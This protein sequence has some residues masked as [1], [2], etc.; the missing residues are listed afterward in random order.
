MTKCAGYKPKLPRQTTAEERIE[1]QLLWLFVYYSF[2]GFLLEVAFARV[3]R[4]PKKDRKCF[5]L[6]PLC[7]VYGIG[8]L[9]IRGL[10]L[11]GRDP[12]WV[13]AVGFVAATVAELLTGAFYR[14]GLGV[15]FWNYRDV[16][17]NF[18]GLVCL[19]FSLCW[20]V[21]ALGMVYWLGPRAAAFAAA[22]PRWMDVP[23]LCLLAADGAVSAVA[24]R[25]TGTTDVLRW[26][27]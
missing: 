10:T 6:L 13:A 18:K 12:L 8:A 9:M 22:V 25:R 7:P 1:L 21:L 2:L 27:E 24:L 19:P 16:K 17:W 4:H 5:F 15:E 23:M 26:Y 11:F 14:Y 20:T 3:I